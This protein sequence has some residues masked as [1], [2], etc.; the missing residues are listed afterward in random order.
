MKSLKKLIPL[1]RKITVYIPGTSDI[2]K[3]AD[4]SGWAADAAH[5]LSSLYGGATSTENIGYWVSGTGELVQEKIITVF[6]YAEKL[7]DNDVSKVIEF[8]ENMKR[9]LKQ[10]AISLEIDNKLYFV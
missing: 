6:S 3:A 1:N 7:T 4:N 8:C 9:E 5:L 2:D 10:E